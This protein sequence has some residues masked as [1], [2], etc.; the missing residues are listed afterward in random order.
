MEKEIDPSDIGKHPDVIKA[1]QV[2]MAETDVLVCGKCHGVFHFLELFQAH[3]EKGCTNESNFKECR[4]T[5]PKVWA[6]LLWKASQTH[7]DENSN[8]NSWK[9]YQTWVKMDET[10][11]ETW[12]VAG[13]TIQSFGRMGQGSLQEMPVKITKTVVDCNTSQ[14]KKESPL[15]KSPILTRIPAN[16]AMPKLQNV[17]TRQSGGAATAAAIKTVQNSYRIASRTTADNIFGDETVEKILAKRFN[18]RKKMY[19]YLVKWENFTHEQNTWEQVS[20][21]DQCKNLLEHFEEQLAKQK[22]Q[23]AK[24]Q[25]LQTQ[26]QQS[27]QKTIPTSVTPVSSPTNRPVRNSKSKAIDQV[28]QWCASEDDNGPTLKR[29]NASMTDEDDF[30]DEQDGDFGF[31]VVKK[32]K[33]DN[34]AVAQALIKAGQSGN[35]RI[36]QVNKTGSPPKIIQATTLPVAKGINGSGSFETK[37]SAEIVISRDSKATGVVKK[38]GAILNATKNNLTEATIRVIS[39]GESVS[40][41]VVRISAQNDMVEKVTPAAAAGN[42]GNNKA[43]VQFGNKPTVLSQLKANAHAAIVK[44]IASTPVVQKPVFKTTTPTQ[45]F[46]AQQ[47]RFSL[48]PDT[49]IHNKTTITRI[50]KSSSVPNSAAKATPEHTTKIITYRNS[51]GKIVKK[52]IPIQNN[53]QKDSIQINNP[54]TNAQHDEEEEDDNLPDPFP[55]EL[56]PPEPDSPPLPMSLCPITGKVLLKAEGE[57]TPPPSPPAVLEQKQKTPEFKF[58]QVKSEAHTPAV[59][60]AQEDEE[61]A[62]QTLQPMTNE[63]GTPLLV[64]GEDGTIYQIAGKN[65]EGQTI[66][67]AQG[68]DGEQQCV[69]VAAQEDA[70]NILSMGGGIQEG[71]EEMT[72]LMHQQ[73][74]TGVVPEEDQ[75]QYII[76]EQDDGG[77][78][79]QTLTLSIEGSDSQDGGQITAEVVQADLPSPGGTRRVVL[80]LPDGNFMMTEVDEEQYRSLNLVS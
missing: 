20:H 59:E 70:E 15:K 79:P 43:G 18:P 63:D 34:P 50:P 76:K 57:K 78:P 73:H 28:K 8:V 21:F 24:F 74:E 77:T 46:V 11:R 17:N 29:K 13:R 31:N 19:E 48:S 51:E 69:Y 14:E 72:Q 58:N 2:A 23:R 6:F 42:V 65:E 33:T 75:T 62:M 25:Q 54:F 7:S 10:L 27:G 53:F 71:G 36:V 44:P 32:I 67:I 1:A 38:P 61:T 56:P 37:N 3:K 64:T 55:V 66:L 22:E 49:T 5:K 39:K 30:S 45:H 68:A 80:L 60:Q 9:L 16:Q 40:S 12:V 41:G 47:K 4:E 35:V 52:T 26:K